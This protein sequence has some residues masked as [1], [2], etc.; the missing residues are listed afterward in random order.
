[1]VR[2]HAFIGLGIIK[3][4]LI[5]IFMI[6]VIIHKSCKQKQVHN[7]DSYCSNKMIKK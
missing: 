3:L 1:M 5:T 4:F 7:D 6:I 2:S